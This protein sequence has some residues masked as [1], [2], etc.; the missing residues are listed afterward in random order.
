MREF[1]FRAWDKGK[2]QMFIPIA[3][4]LD[5]GGRV[6]KIFSEDREKDTMTEYPFCNFVFMQWA[7][8]KDK[9][10]KD[11]Y[12]GDIVNDGEC[13]F[14]VVF[15]YGSFDFVQVNSGAKVVGMQ[16]YIYATERIEIIGNIFENEDL[17]DE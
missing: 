6:I 2:K 13:N 7:G 10:G 12:E 8:L 9:T 17:L 14:E 11:I 5:E 3:L 16:Q 1:K 4:R 15:E